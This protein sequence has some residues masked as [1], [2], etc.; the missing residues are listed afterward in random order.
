MEGASGQWSASAG[1]S[2]IS[3]REDDDRYMTHSP[4]PPPGGWYGE[5]FSAQREGEALLTETFLQMRTEYAETWFRMH[6]SSKLHPA[7]VY[8]WPYQ[9]PRN[10]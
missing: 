4:D 7:V 8:P 10:I 1:A 6:A 3:Q 5:G 2:K 9:V